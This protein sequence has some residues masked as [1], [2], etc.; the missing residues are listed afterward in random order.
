MSFYKSFLAKA[1]TF[2]WITLMVVVTTLAVSLWGFQF[3]DNA[4][5][6]NSTQ[7]QFLVDYWMPEGTDIYKTEEGMKKVEEELLDKEKYPNIIKSINFCRFP[8]LKIS[9]HFFRRIN[10]REIRNVS[11]RS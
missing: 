11:Y 3:I 9:A 8:S 10:K 5:F 6:P 4:F 2:K 7:P 1:L